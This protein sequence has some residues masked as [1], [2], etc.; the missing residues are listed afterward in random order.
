MWEWLITSVDPE[1][2]HLVTS[3]V[4]WHG[5]IMVF[6]WGFL[7]PLAIVLTRF[8]KILPWQNWPQEL[9]N[10]TWWYS[11][12]GGHLLAIIL[13]VVGLW[14][15][16]FDDGNTG[17]HYVH[18]F[19]AYSLLVFVAFQV[20]S[21]LIRGSKGGPTAPA[22]DGSWHGDHYSMTSWRL[23]FEFFHKTIGYITLFL[24]FLTVPNGLWI[25]NAPNWIFVLLFSWWSV[26]LMCFFLLQRK[27]FA[28]E[29]YQAI[30]GP[31]PQH[32]GN[33]MPP[34]GWGVKRPS[35]TFLTRAGE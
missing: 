20:L 32:P 25:A 27:G 29:T 9:D 4:S 34:N 24:A 14:I 22:K 30:W 13:T 12:L 6:A 11:H 31:D 19:L 35:D 8:A 1:R 28:V 33:M 16:L 15:V 18:R 26:L 23:Y 2:T 10:Q 3:G 7:S 17:Q 21:G 5:R